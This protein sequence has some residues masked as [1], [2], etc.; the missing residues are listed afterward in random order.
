MKTY[1]LKCC[2]QIVIVLKGEQWGAMRKYEETPN[3]DI[4]NMWHLGRNMRDEISLV[5]V[6]GW[7]G[8]KVMILA[9]SWH[10]I[11]SWSRQVWLGNFLKKEKIDL[12]E[13]ELS[14]FI[15]RTMETIL[16]GTQHR[17]IYV[18]Q[19]EGLPASGKC[20]DMWWGMRR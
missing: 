16:A 19:E 3:L 14:N 15:L 5:K 2:I 8:E 20:V 12:G 7:G 17:Q 11:R 18:F 10:V 6:V 9:R 13:C 4:L 1:I